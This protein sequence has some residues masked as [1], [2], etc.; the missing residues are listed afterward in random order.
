MNIIYL[1]YND[2]SIDT[3]LR[4][5]DKAIEDIKNDFSQMEDIRDEYSEDMIET[6]IREEAERKLYE[7]DY[8]FNV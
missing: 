7:Y 5:M 2:L 3:Q 6:A 8:V 1:N 4:I